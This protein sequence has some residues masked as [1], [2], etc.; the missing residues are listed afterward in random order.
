MVTL[1]WSTGLSQCTNDACHLSLILP[2]W[3]LNV[4]LQIHSGI[5]NSPMFLD[6]DAEHT[7]M[8][9]GAY[10]CVYICCM[11]LHGRH[12]HETARVRLLKAVTT[13]QIDHL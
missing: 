1:M 3:H 11:V 8:G 9:W 6:K 13:A 4:V 10:V 7:T 2:A 12:S 5:V